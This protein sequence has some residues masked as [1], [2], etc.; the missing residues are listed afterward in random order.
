MFNIPSNSGLGQE[1]ASSSSGAE[2]GVSGHV[3]GGG[4]GRPRNRHR[5]VDDFDTVSVCSTCSSSSSDDDDY[6]Y[7]LPPRRQYGGV[8]I[9]Y[10]PNDAVALA[11]A[12]SQQQ[13][14]Q[15]RNG[16]LPPLMKG[17]KDKNCI[18]S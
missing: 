4:S 17:D 18:I 3:S 6:P 14:Q 11:A 5:P 13:Q 8:R 12:R 1:S 16:T 15:Q 7:H 2:A 9:S 10:V